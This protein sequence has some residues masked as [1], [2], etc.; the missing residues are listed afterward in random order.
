MHALRTAAAVGTGAFMVVASAPAYAGGGHSGQVPIRTITTQLDGPLGLDVLS[1][2]VALVAESESGEVTAV[3]LRTGARTAL[4]AKVP[5][6]AGVAAYG[7]KIFAV[8]GGPNPDGPPAPPSK[9]PPASVLVADRNG[10]NVRVLA[11][12]LKY[13]LKRNPDGQRQFDKNGKPYDALSNPFSLTATRWGLLVA[14]G[15]GN[16]VLR[17][18]PWTGRVSTFFVPPNPRT[19]ECL[20]P[21]AQA[22][23]GTK[24][25]DS[26][27]T[28]VA[29]HG[30][31]VYV[32]T[33]GAEKPGAS[34][35]Y[36]LD[37]RTGK[38]L[39]KYGGFT[40]LTGVAVGPR[41]TLFA[42]EVLF[43][44]PAGP[45]PAGFDPSQVGRLTRIDGH[46]VTHAAVATPTGIEFAGGRLYSTSGSIAG[47]FGVKHGGRL[48]EVRQSAFR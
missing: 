14:D 41:G 40:S 19:K 38:V 24:G 29:V 37:G 42:S 30:R 26:V 1:P 12:L 10:K 23:P 15:G 17:V 31:H 9:Y 47:I 6:V 13:E 44:A 45:P 18:D 46:R 7:G 2:H 39:R 36:K 43:G 27:P 4:I 33:L 34:V 32:S 28:G 5:G 25:C 11:N 35:I 3:N 20:A 21:G 8:L 16:D 22:N 48:V